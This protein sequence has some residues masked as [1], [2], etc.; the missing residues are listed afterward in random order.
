[1]NIVMKKIRNVKF[2]LSPSE[3]MKPGY[4]HVLIGSYRSMD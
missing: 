1:M 2:N 4:S 3:L